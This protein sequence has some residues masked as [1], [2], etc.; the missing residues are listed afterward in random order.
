MTPGPIERLKPYFKPRP[1]NRAAQAQPAT[2]VAAPA[3]QPAQ[4]AQQ[5]VQGQPA[6]PAQQAAPT[7]PAAAANGSPLQVRR[8]LLANRYA[9]LQS[10]LGGL[11]YEMAIRDAFRLELLVQRAA[12]L[13]TVDTELNSVEQ[14]LGLVPTPPPTLTPAATRNCPSCGAAV[15]AAALYCGRCGST[16]GTPPQSGPKA[17]TP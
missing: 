16:L 14:Q 5:P 9:V 3:Q 7:P 8:E 12:E 4:P 10:D 11:V 15:E 13:Q 2:A 6:T 17:A 1:R